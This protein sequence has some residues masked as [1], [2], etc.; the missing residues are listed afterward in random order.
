MRAVTLT[1]KQFEAGYREFHAA[2]N[3]RD[4]D[5]AFAT[6][7]PDCEFRTI[8]ELLGERV[9]VGPDQVRRYWEDAST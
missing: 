5:R 1:L 8:N 3:R 6:L 4:L 2:L 9:L 7:A